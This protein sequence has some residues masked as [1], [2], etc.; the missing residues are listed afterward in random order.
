M[1]HMYSTPY[2]AGI[3]CVPTVQLYSF[4]PSSSQLQMV[5]PP[6]VTK[7]ALR[8]QEAGRPA[9]LWYLSQLLH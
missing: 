5:T 9:H 2:Y 7:E 3:W 8:K 6:S 4:L 1:L